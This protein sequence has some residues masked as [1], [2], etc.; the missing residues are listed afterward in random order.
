MLTISG[1]PEEAAH[2]LGVTL[3]PLRRPPDLPPQLPR[4][5]AAHVRQ[6]VPFELLPHPLVR[7]QIRRVTRQWLDPET[8]RR[9]H[10]QELLHLPAV[11]DRGAIPE[12]PELAARQAPRHM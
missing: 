1:F 2:H 7:V 8:P 5:E 12:D 11:V 6:V 4:V 9:R 10:G 3:Q